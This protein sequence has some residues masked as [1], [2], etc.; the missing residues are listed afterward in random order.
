M[1][2]VAVL[3]LRGSCPRFGAGDRERAGRGGRLRRPLCRRRFHR[4]LLLPVT[5]FPSPAP[6]CHE[7]PPSL[8]KLV[9][10]SP[11][12]RV[13][14]QQDPEELDALGG[15]T[16]AF[17]KADGFALDVAEEVDVVDAVEGGL[18]WVREGEEGRENERKKRK[19]DKK[20][21]QEGGG[22]RH[23]DTQTRKNEK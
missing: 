5:P 6:Q 7:L 1:L 18:A 15:D 12:D 11:V 10:R 2:L 20:K 17:G 14:V 3:V 8:V 22:D 16:D 21:R 23:T 13:P 19:N 9:E 4:P